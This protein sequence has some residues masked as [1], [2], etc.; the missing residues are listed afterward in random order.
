MAG[1]LGGELADGRRPPWRRPVASRIAARRHDRDARRIPAE[2]RR[3]VQR[4]R[5]RHQY[6]NRTSE[7]N[8][9]EWLVVT[10]V[11]QDPQ[12]L[13]SRFARSSHFKKVADTPWNPT[14]CEAS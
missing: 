10:T 13:T 2:E 1:N 6:F 4:E 9:D 12:Y 14:A 8:G 7:P 5:G 11:V 3:P